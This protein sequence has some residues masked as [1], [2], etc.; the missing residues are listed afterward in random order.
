MEARAEG[1]AGEQT[2]DTSSGAGASYGKAGYELAGAVRCS[3]V[4]RRVFDLPEVA[5][6]ASAGARRARPTRQLSR[7]AIDDRREP[8]VKS[9]TH[10]RS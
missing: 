6:L 2:R 8:N 9:Q 5:E 10:A 3:A 1:S 4:L 7:S